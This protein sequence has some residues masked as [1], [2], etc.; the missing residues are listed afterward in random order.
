VIILDGKCKV[1]N[2][3]DG[4]VVATLKKGDVIGDSDFLKYTGYEFFG[5]I[6]AAND[7]GASRGVDCIIID[8]PA[9]FIS[10]F[11]L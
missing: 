7:E 10:Y 8:D 4:Y 9:S 3:S 6:F 2:P 5:N 11:E 1:I